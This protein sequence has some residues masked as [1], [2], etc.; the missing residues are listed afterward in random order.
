MNQINLCIRK[1]DKGD[2]YDSIMYNLRRLSAIACG[3]YYEPLSDRDA[4]IGE[5][6]YKIAYPEEEE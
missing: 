5:I 3:G 4:E 6:L 1:S 2:Y